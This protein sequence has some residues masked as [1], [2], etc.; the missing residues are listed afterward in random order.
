MSMTGRQAPTHI[1]NFTNPPSERTKFIT[2]QVS[3][4]ALA[5]LFVSL[6]LISRYMIIKSPGWDDHTIM[7]AMVFNSL[8]FCRELNLRAYT[9]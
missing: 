1:P 6:R 9:S 3:M 5:F 8:I 2:I 7:V 4:T